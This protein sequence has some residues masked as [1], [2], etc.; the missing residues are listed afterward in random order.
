MVQHSDTTSSLLNEI[1]T[2][3]AAREYMLSHCWPSHERFCPRCGK[4][5]YYDLSGGRYRCSECKYTFQDFS[6]RW[7][8]NGNLSPLTWL[9]ILDLFIQERTVHELASELELSYNATYKAVSTLRFAIM[10]H[11][12]DAAQMFGPETGLGAY[13]KGKKLTG[14]PREQRLPIPVFGIMERN[15]WV[16]IDIVS[17]IA[18]ETVFHF[19]H[20]FHLA[21]HRAGNI[22]YTN[23]YR[24]YDALVFCGDDSLPYEYIRKSETSVNLESGTFWAFAGPRLKRFKGITPQRFPLYLKELEFRFNK[25]P[26]VLF[27]T[28]ARYLCD[29]VPDFEHAAL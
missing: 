23:R 13:L 15:G 6:G 16:F 3:S 26:E 10:A 8:N 24:H 2:E 25:G 28:L 9:R 7:I 22:V 4:Q 1:R 12:T 17:G 11:A 20:S 18:A 21:M 14:D 5:K 19:N 29:L 27:E